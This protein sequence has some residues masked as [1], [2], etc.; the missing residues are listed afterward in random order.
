LDFFNAESIGLAE[1]TSDSQ[2]KS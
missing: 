1:N 2:S